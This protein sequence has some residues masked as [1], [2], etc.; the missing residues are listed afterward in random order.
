ML[1]ANAQGKNSVFTLGLPDLHRTGTAPRCPRA[2]L[3]R[4]ELCLAIAV[5]ELVLAYFR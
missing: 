4:H 2:P 1:L 3:A 5:P